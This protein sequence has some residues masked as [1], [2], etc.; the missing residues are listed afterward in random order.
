[1]KKALLLLVLITAGLI[2]IAG[3]QGPS[4]Q[5]GGNIT[6]GGAT[7]VPATRC[8]SIQLPSDA[9]TLTATITG[10]WSGTLQLEYSA[11]SGTTWTSSSSTTSDEVATVPVASFTNFRVRCSTYTS[12]N[13]GVYFNVAGGKSSGPLQV[14]TASVSSAQIKALSATD[15]PLIPAPGVGKMIQ[16]STFNL[17]YVAGSTPY[18]IDPDSTLSLYYDVSG[19]SIGSVSQSNFLDQVASRVAFPMGSSADS[20]AQVDF[21]NSPVVLTNQDGP[22]ATAG[23]GTLR[24]TIYYVIVNL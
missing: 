5:F 10:T 2:G 22:D 18:T 11:D 24:V 8:V 21:E 19:Q 7:C 23:N 4:Y 14:V 3:A 15:V 1:M 16:V 9:S 12:G 6:A 20:A 17:Q 13:A